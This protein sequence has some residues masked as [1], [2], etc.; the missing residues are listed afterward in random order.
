MQGLNLMREF[1]M[2]KM[3][4]KDNIKEYSNK[5]LNIANKVR[6]LGKDFPHDKTV[7]KILAT[8]PGKYE[9]KSLL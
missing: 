2:L 5:L 8:L 7:K 3:N 4:E 9:A 1:E 6:L